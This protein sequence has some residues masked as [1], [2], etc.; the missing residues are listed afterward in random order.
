MLNTPV[1]LPLSVVRGGVAEGVVMKIGGWR[2]RSVFD[3]Y[4]IV[5]E[6][7]IADASARSRK[8]IDVA[9]RSNT[10]PKSMQLKQVKI[11][12]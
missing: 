6:A 3:R 4:N 10:G 9:R 2:T 5:S 7:D 8:G 12:S 11:F 1:L